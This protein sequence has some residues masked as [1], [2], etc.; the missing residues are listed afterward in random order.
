MSEYIIKITRKGRNGEEEGSH[1]YDKKSDTPERS[2]RIK[3]LENHALTFTEGEV[4]EIIPD[5]E[6]IYKKYSDI[7][8]ELVRIEVMNAETKLLVSMC[9]FNPD[10]EPELITSRFELMDI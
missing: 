8:G 10:F 6:R 3:N 1:Y 2:Y 5:I 9:G 4:K 7:N